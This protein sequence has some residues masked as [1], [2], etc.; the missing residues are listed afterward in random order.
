[1]ISKAERTGIKGVGEKT[2]TDYIM[3]IPVIHKVFTK[4]ESN[5]ELLKKVSLGNGKDADEDELLE[6]MIYIKDVDLLIETITRKN[7]KTHKGYISPFLTSTSYSK[8]LNKINFE[9]Y[10]LEFEKVN[11]EVYGIRKENVEG[12][13][14]NMIDDFEEEKIIWQVPAYL[15]SLIYASSQGNYQKKK[16]SDDV[17]IYHFCTTLKTKRRCSPK[18][19]I[20]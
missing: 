13:D 10:R 11:N 19:I 18:R 15:N 14:E 20:G 2:A 6:N 3:K 8:K 7:M 16:V 12:A 9:N 5:E 4:Q 1:M 17:L